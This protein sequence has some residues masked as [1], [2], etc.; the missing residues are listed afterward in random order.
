MDSVLKTQ[1]LR[2]S[3][4]MAQLLGCEHCTEL[5]RS[6]LLEQGDDMDDLLELLHSIKEKP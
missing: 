4:R 5:A 3:L 6:L 1:G 2:L